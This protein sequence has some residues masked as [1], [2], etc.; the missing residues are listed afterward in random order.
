MDDNP[1][2]S[3]RDASESLPANDKTQNDRSHR[4]ILGMAVF[5]LPLFLLW[6]TLICGCHFHYEATFV[7]AFP[8]G[9]G[10]YPFFFYRTRKERFV[11][12]LT[13]IISCFMLYFEFSNNLR[14]KLR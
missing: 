6:N 14:F 3:P 10:F 12:Y 4:F 7:I 13:M 8:I 1:Y 5:Q 11:G 2:Q 9:Y